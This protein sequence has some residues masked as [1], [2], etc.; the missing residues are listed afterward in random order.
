MP[1]PEPG[2]CGRGRARRRAGDGGDGSPIS[3]PRFHDVY[4]REYTY[5]L[6]AP[7]EIVGLHLVAAAEVGKLEL[8][9]LPV[10]GASLAAALKGRRPVDYATEGV[11]VADIYDSARLE[12]GMSFSGPGDRRGSRHHDRRPSRP[13]R[14]HRRL[15]QHP[16]RARAV[17]PPMQPV[18][19]PFTLDIIQNSLEAIA[20]EMFAVMRKT[21]MSAIIYEVLDLGHRDHRR[22]GRD[23]RLGRRH[24]RL[25]R[26]ARQGG[27]GDPAQALA[28]TE[29][30]ARRRLHHQRSLFRRRDPSQRHRAR[31]AG[32]RRRR[33]RRLGGHYRPLERRRRQVPGS[34]SIDAARFSRKACACPRSR[35]SRRARRTTPSSTS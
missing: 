9:R 29:H 32:L 8:A 6:T 31:D 7:V 19:D 34:M 14:R 13:E 5:R 3:S 18:A 4:E 23:R 16:Y 12:P 15:W 28:P 2:A 30:R 21:A 20:D 17:R 24:S 33:D 26:R 1:L 10:T 35:S 11:H 27:E 22:R 25:H